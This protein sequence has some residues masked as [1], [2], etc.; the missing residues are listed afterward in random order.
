VNTLPNSEQQL[1]GTPPTG[2]ASAEGPAETEAP[3]EPT[4]VAV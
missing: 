2:E 3:P 1:P 4:P